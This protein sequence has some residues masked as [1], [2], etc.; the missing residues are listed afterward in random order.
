M[1]GQSAGQGSVFPWRGWSED[2][3]GKLPIGLVAARRDLRVET[4][5]ADLW[6]ARQRHVLCIAV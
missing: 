4:A 6:M 5:S 3:L 1:L 2:G